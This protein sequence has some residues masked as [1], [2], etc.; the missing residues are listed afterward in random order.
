[1]HNFYMYTARSDLSRAC[2]PLMFQTAEIVSEVFWM[3]LQELLIRPQDGVIYI[4]SL[5]LQYL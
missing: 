3:F 5:E 4:R 1:M 2:D